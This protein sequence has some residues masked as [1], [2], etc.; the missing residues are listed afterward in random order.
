MNQQPETIIQRE[1][2]TVVE[3]FGELY[4]VDGILKK[5]AIITDL[6]KYNEELI[7]R[8]MSNQVL[9]GKFTQAI[10]EVIILKTNEL[11]QVLETDEYWKNSYTRYTNKIGLTS[12]GCYI[13]ENSD[14]VLDFPYK[15]TILKAGM[16][17]E[18]VSKEDAE[19]SFL[20]E[21]VAREEIDVLLDKKV[22]K[23]IK[24]YDEQGESEVSSLGE[25]DNLII[26]GNNLLALYSLKERYAGKVKLIYIDPPYYFIKN[27]KEDS[28]VYNSNFKLSTWLTF[29]KNRLEIARDLLEDG[30]VL[31]IS[32]DEDGQA[33]L[34]VLMDDIFNKN[35]FVETFIWRNTDNAD[36]LGAKSRSGIEYIH[37]Y[38]KMKDSS[39]RWIGKD[40]E[41]E[42]APLLNSSNSAGTLVF[43]PGII[44]FSIPDGIYTAEE[45]HSV[46]LNDNLVVENGRNKNQIRMTGKFKW[47]QKKLDKE[48]DEGSYFLIKSKKFSIRY[49]KAVAGNVA[50]EKFI[51]ERYLSKVFGVGT[52]EDANTHLKSLDLNFPYSKPESLIAFFI[53]AITDESDIIL[54]FFLGSGTTAAV[55]HKMNRQYI[56][57]DQM[58]YIKTIA[59]ERL[60][61]VVDGEQGGIS[62]DVNWQGGG[63]FIYAELMDRNS[64]F[65]DLIVNAHNSEQ[66]K[67]AFDEMKETLDFDFRINLQEVSNSIWEEDLETQR[68]VLI[69]IIDKNL[70]YYNYFEIDDEK[71][72]SQLTET[73]YKFNKDFYG[74]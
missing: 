68:K 4:V 34:K 39:V 37:A 26:K 64:T 45:N 55:A 57:V 67:Q 28:F 58:E 41:N 61:K 30:G 13:S 62:K 51:D 47:S 12:N 48:V 44:R 29:M 53:R 35:D 14:V 32:I 23:N 22:L 49:Q 5:D 18:D 8:I 31:L 1:L 72:K 71:V 33:Y 15:D 16:T 43:R 56:G 73:E 65:I 25:N 21:I 9:N 46:I 10:G 20:N 69:K 11:I 7:M 54:D 40:A 19:E 63:S 70:L 3:S 38:E 24:K 74:E 50:P 17:K 6:D 42:D 36:S 66:L 2:R 52:N 60:K 59:I 27:K